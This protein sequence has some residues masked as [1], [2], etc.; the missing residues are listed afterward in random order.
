MPTSSKST[1]VVLDTTELRKDWLFESFRMQL[2]GIRALDGALSVYI[3][4]P[5]LEELI[6]HYGREA[7]DKEADLARLRHNLDRLGVPLAGESQRKPLGYREFLIER[8]DEVLSFEISEWP[9]VAHSQLVQRAVARKRPFDQK[10]GGYR[11]SLVWASVVELAA[12]GHDVALVTA[13]LTFS[14]KDGLLHPELA[15]EIEPL[16]GTVELVRDLSSWLLATL[17]SGPGDVREAVALE[18]DKEFTEYYLASDM[19]EWLIPE[20]AEIGFSHR[21][22]RFEVEETIWDGD[23]RKVTTSSPGEGALVA[24]YD[25]D[26]VVE[27]R[28]LLSEAT[29]VEHDWSVE[30]QMADEV[31]VTG[32]LR[33]IVRV[34]VLFEAD[35][36]FSVDVLSW[37]RADGRPPGPGISEPDPTQTPLF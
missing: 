31:L 36:S 15:E 21:P 7:R 35:L 37:R 30:S 28:A 27:F 29:E 4:A 6:A 5:V 24:E 23:I 33:M 16:S 10:G 8:F 26:Q 22:I 18:R 14:E 34:A 9:T 20:A 2:L 32:S 13:D 12:D 11:D 25:L 17:P 1:S 3:P 19:Q